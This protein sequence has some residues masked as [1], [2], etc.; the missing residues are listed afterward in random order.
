M[1]ILKDTR[2]FVV[3]IQQ[4]L[5]DI[6]VTKSDEAKTEALDSMEGALQHLDKLIKFYT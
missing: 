4:L 1:F 5:T 6:G 2:Y 3:Q